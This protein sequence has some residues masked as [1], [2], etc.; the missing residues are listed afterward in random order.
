MLGV[1]LSK[2]L[3]KAQ[4]L[5]TCH[6]HLGLPIRGPL[7][8]AETI[9]SAVL[10][11][12]PSTISRINLEINGNNSSRRTHHLFP[13]STCRLNILF[14]MEPPAEFFQSENSMRTA[15]T[16]LNGGKP[17]EDFFFIVTDEKIRARLLLQKNTQVLRV[18]YLV[19]LSPQLEQRALRHHGFTTDVKWIATSVCHLC[20]QKF[21]NS[22]TLQ[23]K[24]TIFVDYTKQMYGHCRL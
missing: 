9:L 1:S 20:P 7:S 2:I 5:Q 10:S 22:Q 18:K 23:T 14:L 13:R 17:T 15:M 19:A 21:V 11:K 16:F 6:F 4:V 12:R 24:D 3:L 8:N